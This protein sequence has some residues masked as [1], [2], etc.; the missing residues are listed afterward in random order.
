MN[1]YKDIKLQ[2]ELWFRGN[3]DVVYPANQALSSVYEKY[4]V[5]YP[6][7]FYLLDNNLVVNFDNFYDTFFIQ[8]S[9]GYIF[10]KYTYDQNQIVPFN[11]V[12]NYF[13]YKSN[14]NI[15]YW[16]NENKK[17]VYWVEFKTTDFDP[18]YSNVS[19]INFSFDF[20]KFDLTTGIY[21]NIFS[22]KV[23]L[24]S[25]NTQNL[26][27]SNGVKENP[28]LTYNSDTNLFNLSFIIRNDLNVFGLV[29]V[30]FSEKYIEEVNT[31]I[32]FGNVQT[33]KY[34]ATPTPTPTNTASA[35]PTPT[36]TPHAS[37]KPTAT[38]TAK[39]TPTPTMTYIPPVV[40]KSVKSVYISFD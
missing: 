20:N 33:N 14:L 39:P 21:E 6:E 24:Y 27:A 35:T 3:D 19:V 40:G 12:F 26:T 4:K 38:T 34:T 7:L 32:P 22:E 23:N 37:P 11:Q 16:L 29:S 8:T 31:F 10:E 28:K 30:N 1:F 25:L 13:K 9:A 15:D 18:G 5:E 36:N 17:I 2:G